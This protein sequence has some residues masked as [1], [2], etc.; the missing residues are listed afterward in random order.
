MRLANTHRGSENSYREKTPW[1]T[2]DTPGDERKG[3][4][5]GNPIHIQGYLNGEPKQVT[6]KECCFKDAGSGV[7]HELI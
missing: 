2:T 6:H 5:N 1:A 7:R 4:R 3:Q